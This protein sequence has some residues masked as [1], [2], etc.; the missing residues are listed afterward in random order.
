MEEIIYNYLGI[1]QHNILQIGVTF[2]YGGFGPGSYYYPVMIQLVFVFPIIY[3]IVKRHKHKGVI[4]CGFFN[5]FY[6]VLVRCY[7]MNEECYRLLI[8]RYTLLIA[9]GCYLA[10]HDRLSHKICKIV[11]F[12]VGIIYI[13]I[14]V[15]VGK[16]PPITMYWTT[17]SVFA[18]LYIIPIAEKIIF[19]NCRNGLIELIGKASYNIF[20]VQMIYYNGVDVVY[21][22]IV[23]RW[24]Q[25]TCN[26]FICI[27]GGLL[28]YFL[29]KP[30]T[31]K[32]NLYVLNLVKKYER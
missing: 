29:E 16:V 3:F 13:L 8:F 7:G 6:E 26:V 10:T 25:L 22:F 30:L 28:F 11:C 17:T 15:Y 2:F 5:I 1:I 9:Y 20:L 23:N 19:N 27:G 14:F 31:Q 32:I 21:K 12:F 18:C 4:L 24:L